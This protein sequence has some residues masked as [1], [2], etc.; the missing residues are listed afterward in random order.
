M[1]T[2]IIGADSAIGHALMLA[3]RQGG[4]VVHATSRRPEASAQGYIHLDLAQ[5]DLD[6]TPLPFVDV[7][8]ICAAMTGFSACQANPALA[9]RINTQAPVALAKRL[10]A[11]GAHS[12]F[13]STNARL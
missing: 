2:L 9:R 3:L 8:F 6:R 12:I 1:S 10:G 13:L 7:V 5:S 11:D 4:E